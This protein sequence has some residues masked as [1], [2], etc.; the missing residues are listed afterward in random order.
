MQ[1][2]Y[3][4]LG[5]MSGTSGDGV[6][7]SIIY[8]NGIDQ[9][10]VIKDKYFEYDTNIYKEIHSLKEKIFHINDLQILS[11]EL[12]ELEKKI[13][14]FHARIIKELEFNNEDFIVGFHGQTI[15]HNS[16][17]KISKQLGNG[18]LLSQLT[19]KKIIFNFRKNDIING[20]EGAPLAPIFHQLIATQKNFFLP[21]CFLN[22]GGIS[23]ITIVKKPIGSI[24]LFSKDIG[25]GN[26]LIDAWVRKNSNKK[27]DKNGQLAAKG[28]KNKL[29]LEQAEEL[30]SHRN[31]KGKL[32]FDISD[33]DISFARG[34]S[35]EDGATTLTQFTANI[36]GEEI[37]SYLLE[38]NSNVKEIL[39]CGG[40]RNNKVLLKKISKN[41]PKIINFKLI[42]EY[43]MNGDFIES[44]AFA[45]LA[46]R[47]IL[48]LPITFPNTTGCLK[49]CSGGELSEN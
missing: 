17:E 5:L 11:K 45:F 12:F 6:D 43:N 28:N 34:L 29:I 26:C 15:Y 1:K 23:N 2:K 38:F 13:T 27:F 44:Q 8:S 19:K 20:G 18:Q 42:D 40:G 35:L 7:A 25:P 10:K 21:V 32:S 39:I 36:I 22:I 24:E 16:Q 49:P 4:S 47:S 3:T 37:S 33:F 30:Y 48:K 31:N 9:I 14:L 46:I 41:I